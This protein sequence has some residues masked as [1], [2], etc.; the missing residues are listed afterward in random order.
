M[1][2]K[3]AA[4][5]DA[6]YS[7]KSYPAEAEQLDS[8]IQK[9]KLSSGNRLLDVACG[10][11]LHIQA[12]RTHGYEAEGLDLDENLVATARERNPGV[13]FH[14]A[15]MMDFGLGRTFDVIT[16]LFS[17]IGY[18][19]TVERMRSAIANMARH[20]DPGGVLIV[21]PWFSPDAALQPL[22]SLSV[23]LPELKV[24]RIVSME[25]IG[26]RSVAHFHY[27]IGKL[28]GVDYLVERHEL[29]L[30]SPAEYRGAFESAGLE[31][32]HDARG[33][34]GRGL[35]IGVKPPVTKGDVR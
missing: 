11:G 20:L 19:K 30:F 12:L 9:R 3:S 7:F 23:D 6:I 21:E 26:N 16:C 33:L 10:T 25:K 35:W 17:A 32:T 8:I 31:T 4:F 1:Y 14:C 18:V 22:G 15:D 24:A 27:L 13:T 29:G 2:T 34:I 5:Y 28:G